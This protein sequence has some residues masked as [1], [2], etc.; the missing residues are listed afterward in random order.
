MVALE[1]KY[2]R[3][4]LAGLYNRARTINSEGEGIDKTNEF[5]SIV[6]A[7]LVIYIE[8]VR[9]ADEFGAL[10]FKLSDLRQQYSSRM[11]ELGATLNA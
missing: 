5:S 7:E 3:R 4:C 11:E 8:E 6:F 9:Q 1:A 2:H 10:V